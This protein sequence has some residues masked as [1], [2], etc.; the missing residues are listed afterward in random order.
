MNPFS[1]PVYIMGVIAVLIAINYI[2]LAITQK[3]NLFYF[4]FAAMSLLIAVYDFTSAN[5]YESSS[6]SQ[7]IF[8]QR[9]QLISL[10]LFSISFLWFIWLWGGF[11]FR[12]PF[13]FFITLYLLLLTGGLTFPEFGGFSLNRM[14]PVFIK[15][16]FGYNHTIFESKPGVLFQLLFCLL[17]SGYLFVFYQIYRHKKNFHPDEL[18]SLL[19]GMI[20]F[21]LAAMNDTFIGLGFYH[22]IYLMEYGYLALVIIMIYNMQK[23]FLRVFDQ[24]EELRNH[25]EERVRMRTEELTDAMDEL[26]TI[27]EKLIRTN[28]EMERIQRNADKD[29]RIAAHIQ[30]QLLPSEFNSFSQWDLAV[31]FQ[32]VSQFS[33]G[34]GVSGDF[35]DIYHKGD[36]FHGLALFDVSGHG[37]SSSLITIMAKSIIFR[38]F[39][40]HSRKKLDEVAKKINLELNQELRNVENFLSGIL[41]RAESAGLEYINAGHPDILVRRSSGEVFCGLPSDEGNYGHI[42]GVELLPGS[43]QAVSIPMQSNDMVLLFT[44]GLVE[45]KNSKGEEFGNEPLAEIFAQCGANSAQECLQSI[46]ASY[47]SFIGSSEQVDDITILILRKK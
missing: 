39:S 13:Y 20:F 38:N 21:F 8:W 6:F 33:R 44:D 5:L 34:S 28:L 37:I 46:L 42:L 36:E 27:N 2:W 47:R 41:L 31:F 12:F 11:S 43:F 35:Y 26:E 14:Q 23:R 15:I 3:R 16:G 10:T 7:G 25:L 32:P 45:G 1:F 30:R 22:F 29:M 4:S 9:Y 19:I 18:H 17:L 40:Q 24:N